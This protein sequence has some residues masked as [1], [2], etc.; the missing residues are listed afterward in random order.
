M[1]YAY[2]YSSAYG[3]DA[4]QRYPVTRGVW[5]NEV[6]SNVFGK[7]WRVD[8]RDGALGAWVGDLVATSAT[9]LSIGRL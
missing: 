5:Y 8:Y 3:W 1:L 9:Q 2:L 6:A 4:V 7:N